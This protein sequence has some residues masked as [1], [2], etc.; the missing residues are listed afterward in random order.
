MIFVSAG[1]IHATMLHS[2]Q[3][4]FEKSSLWDTSS[5]WLPW[6]AGLRQAGG[7]MEAR[8]ACVSRG[9]RAIW[10]KCSQTFQARKVS[11]I[12]VLHPFICTIAFSALL[13]LTLPQLHRCP[14][15]HTFW[16]TKHKHT[17]MVMNTHLH[18]GRIRVRGQRK[19][20]DMGGSISSFLMLQRIL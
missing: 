15:L 14:T 2:N 16:H 4:L 12:T 7:K 3:S 9:S 10:P 20:W 17:D 18:K 8:C 5:E 1:L 19:E 11:C 6:R 13:T